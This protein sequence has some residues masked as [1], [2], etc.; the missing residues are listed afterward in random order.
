MREAESRASV[1]QFFE[2]ASIA[3]FF[4]NVSRHALTSHCLLHNSQIELPSHD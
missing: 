3:S 1:E 2:N 4:H